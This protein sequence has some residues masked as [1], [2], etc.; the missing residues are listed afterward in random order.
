MKEKISRRRFIG[1]TATGIVG[2]SA[3]YSAKSYAR[4]TGANDRINMLAHLVDD[5][6]SLD[7]EQHDEK[8]ET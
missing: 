3:G 1:T 6:A 4:I 5:L 2:L 7:I 8:E